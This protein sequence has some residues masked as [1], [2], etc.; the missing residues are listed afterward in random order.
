MPNLLGR[1][2]ALWTMWRFTRTRPAVPNAPRWHVVDQDDPE[3][4]AAVRR[5][6]AARKS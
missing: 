4:R 5:M 2:R 6:E 1:L 3:L